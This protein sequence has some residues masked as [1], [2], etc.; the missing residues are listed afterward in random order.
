MSR[1]LYHPERLAGVC[2]AVCAFALWWA[3]HGPFPATIDPTGGVRTEAQQAE[4][5]AAGRSKA[6]TLA[7][8]PHGRGGALDLYP[9]RVTAGRVA[10]IYLP[11][12]G[13][14]SLERFARYGELA[15]AHNLIWG[16]RWLKAFP[17]HGDC[18]HVELPSWRDLPF[19]PVIVPPYIKA[20][21]A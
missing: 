9:A 18:P 16:G 20:K 14:A 7:E 19:P 13:A 15:E 2:P 3:E 21:E 4:L 10:G 6:K 8:T 17:P 1:L 11:T 12:D 5:Y